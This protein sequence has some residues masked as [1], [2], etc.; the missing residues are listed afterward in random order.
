MGP[1]WGC[2]LMP[3][4]VVLVEI[5]WLKYAKLVDI[6]GMACDV[7]RSETVWIGCKIIFSLSTS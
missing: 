5:Y 2:T 3:V 1:I 7:R 4:P 6:F